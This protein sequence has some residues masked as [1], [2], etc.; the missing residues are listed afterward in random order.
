MGPH[1]ITTTEKWGKRTAAV[2][3]YLFSVVGTSRCD[4]R[5]ACSGA[6]PSSAIVARIF[7]PPATTRAGTAQRAVPTI[8]LNTYVCGAPAAATAPW[9]AFRDQFTA[10]GHSGA[11]RLVLPPSRRAKAPLRRDGGGHS[12]GPEGVPSCAARLCA[13]VRLE[14]STGPAS[15]RCLFSHHP[16]AGQIEQ[17]HKQGKRKE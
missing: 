3:G 12:R 1:P 7:I 10:L 17:R 8:A 13:G 6:T 5:A 14:A 15:S 2:W 11:L 16:R 4:V 9:R